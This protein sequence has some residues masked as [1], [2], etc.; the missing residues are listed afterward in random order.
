V[1]TCFVRFEWDPRK[2]SENV[3]KH[4]ITFAEAA[5]CFE[6]EYAVFLEEIAFP[7]RIAIIAHSKNDRLLFSVFAERENDRIRIISARKVTPPERR[8]YEEGG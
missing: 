5:T 2:A 8:R 3:R 6:D 4:G 7:N 1:H